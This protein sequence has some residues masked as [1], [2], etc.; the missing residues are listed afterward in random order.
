MSLTERTVSKGIFNIFS[1]FNSYPSGMSPSDAMTRVLSLPEVESR[2]TLDMY[3]KRSPETVVTCLS[4]RSDSHIS[5]S[6][7][8]I[9]FTT[10]FFS[11]SSRS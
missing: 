5:I 1:E 10:P 8:K 9:V 2:M 4:R 3:P 11:P 6:H 7:V